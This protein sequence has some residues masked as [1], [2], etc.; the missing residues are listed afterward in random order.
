MQ[1]AKRTE[2]L[3]FKEGSLNDQLD[4]AKSA[5]VTAREN[6][7]VVGGPGWSRELEASPDMVEVAKA[8]GVEPGLVAEVLEAYRRVRAVKG[9][10]RQ[11]ADLRKAM[12][13]EMDNEG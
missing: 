10:T 7:A 8:M 5:M 12:Y 6:L 3:K 1:P 11:V 4:W 2:T 9:T 13:A